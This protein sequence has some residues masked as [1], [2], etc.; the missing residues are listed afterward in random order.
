MKGKKTA[1][2][3]F[4]IPGYD[5]RTISLCEPD[6][7]ASEE[8]IELRDLFSRILHDQYDTTEDKYE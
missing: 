8:D 1:G 5:N 2:D 7:E 4:K 6:D 3:T